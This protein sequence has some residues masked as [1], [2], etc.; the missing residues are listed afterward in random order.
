MS[1]NSYKNGRC[2]PA[3]GLCAAAAI[4]V[5]IAGIQYARASDELSTAAANSQGLEEIIVTA[6]KRE[7]NLQRTPTSVSTITSE[8]GR[9]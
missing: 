8:V 1:K 7:E 3:V 4:N 5:S 6:E 2:W 9:G